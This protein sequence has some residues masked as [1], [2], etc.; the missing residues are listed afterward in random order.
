MEAYIN[1]E[2]VTLSPAESETAK[3]ITEADVPEVE[4]KLQK[5]FFDGIEHPEVEVLFRDTTDSDMTKVTAKVE[6]MNLAGDEDI[7]DIHFHFRRQMLIAVGS[8]TVADWE[9]TTVCIDGLETSVDWSPA[10]GLEFKHP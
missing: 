8:G 7:E 3:I 9:I 10:N 5:I 6:I 2:I 1:V 4:A